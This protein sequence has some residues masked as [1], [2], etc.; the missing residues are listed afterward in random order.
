MPGIETDKF[1]KVLVSSATELRDWLAKNHEQDKSVWLVT[2]LKHVGEKYVSREEVLDELLCFGWID[3]I[4]RK[5]DTDQT[6]QLI[7]PRKTQ[8]WAKSYKDRVAKLKKSGRMCKAGNDVVA[9]AKKNGLRTFMDDVDALI[10]PEDLSRRLNKSKK[11]VTHFES[12]S[13]SYR[14]NVLRWVKLSK[15]DTT[16]KKRI[17]KIFE[18]AKR[19]EKIPQM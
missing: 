8:Y 11:A 16:R 1:E 18:F 19:N 9:E 5:L 15:T 10:V 4:R 17:N 12:S 7:S 3:G 14:R 2:F 6:M 13:P